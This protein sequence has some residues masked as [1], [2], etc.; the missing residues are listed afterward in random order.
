MKALVDQYMESVEHHEI[1][2]DAAQLKVVEALQ[3]ALDRMNDRGWWCRLL[4]KRQQGV[5]IWG[6]VGVGK[7]WLMDQFYRAAP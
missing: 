3:C 1:V 2:Q 6:D 4:K 7:T 5:F